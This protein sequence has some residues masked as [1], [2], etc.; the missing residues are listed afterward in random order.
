GARAPVLG[1]RHCAV[2]VGGGI[3]LPIFP[4]RGSVTV[5]GL[6]RILTGL[7]VA[8]CIGNIDAGTNNLAWEIVPM[9]PGAATP[10]GGTKPLPTRGAGT[11]A[12]AAA[13]STRSWSPA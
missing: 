10:I 2:R 12:F 3:G 5:A 13:S 4:V 11:Q 8:A 7:P 1:S 9:A 6:R